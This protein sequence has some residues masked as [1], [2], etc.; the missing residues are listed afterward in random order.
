LKNLIWRPVVVAALLVGVSVVST[1][2]RS[3]DLPWYVSGSAGTYL[4]QDNN[5]SATT[6]VENPGN[7]NSI[8]FPS[9]NTTTYDPGE[10]GSVA[11]GRAI[12]WGFRA[13][14]ELD[15]AHYSPSDFTPSPSNGNTIVGVSGTKF[16]TSSG[17][18]RNR[19]MGS[20]NLFWDAPLN[21]YLKPYVG[22][23]VGFATDSGSAATFTNPNGWTFTQA[24]AQTTAPIV[25]GEVGLAVALSPRWSIVPAYRYVHFFESGN[26]IAEAANIF[27]L[28]VRYSF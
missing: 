7:G 19:F 22:A 18:T 9:S 4:R 2:A 17:G 16:T 14:V 23:G 12:V 24:A 3:A 21:G 27:K 13:E 10:F 15:F 1:P 26:T 6:E 11:F 25:L 28:G 5:R 8:I 20:A